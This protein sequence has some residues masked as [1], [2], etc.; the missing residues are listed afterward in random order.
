MQ[1]RLTDLTNK[2]VTEVVEDV[3]QLVHVNQDNNKEQVMPAKHEIYLNTMV[4]DV[5]DEIDPYTEDVA[6]CEITQEVLEYLGRDEDDIRQYSEFVKNLNQ[7]KAAG[8][9]YLNRVFDFRKWYRKKIDDGIVQFYSKKVA[10][11]PAN[12]VA[13]LEYQVGYK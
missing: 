11:P 3:N 12:L 13:D 7:S 4:T 2:V 8:K 6:V 1:N 5:P 10:Y 9:A